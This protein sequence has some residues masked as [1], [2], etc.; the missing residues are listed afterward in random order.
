MH[1]SPG[2]NLFL[3]KLCSVCWCEAGMDATEPTV[4]IC[5]GCHVALAHSVRTCLAVPCCPSWVMRMGT[6]GP[7]WRFG[8]IPTEGLLPHEV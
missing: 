5:D 7:L 8:I 3:R 6:A 4:R 1:P 2:K